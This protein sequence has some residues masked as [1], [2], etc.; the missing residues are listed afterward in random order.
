MVVT[1]KQKEGFQTNWNLDSV[2]STTMNVSDKVF[3]VRTIQEERDSVE[4]TEKKDLRTMTWMSWILR[5]LVK[6]HLVPVTWN[7][8][9]STLDFHLLSK[10][11]FLACPVTIVTFGSLLSFLILGELFSTM[12]SSDINFIDKA[13]LSVLPSFIPTLDLYSFLLAHGLAKVPS[14]ALSK[15]LTWPS[16]GSLLLVGLFLAVG[17][18]CPAGRETLL[19]ME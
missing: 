3:V 2:R 11:S 10:A 9:H 4:E 19:L 6:L 8:Q 7:Q 13:V 16:E 18:A 15:D 1:N 12:F 14:L 17:F 5:L